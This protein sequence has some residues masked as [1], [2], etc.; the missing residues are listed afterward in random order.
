MEEHKRYNIIAYIAAN[1]SSSP[2]NLDLI[3][4]MCETI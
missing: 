3:G 4:Y 1:L 2:H